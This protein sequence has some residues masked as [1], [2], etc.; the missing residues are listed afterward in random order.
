MKNRLFSTKMASQLL[1]GPENFPAEGTIT[2]YEE[3]ARNGAAIVCCSM[4]TYP[5]REGKHP[6]MS[7]IDMT[8]REVLSYFRQIT[9]RIHAYGSLASASL[10]NVEPHDVGIC[11]IPNWDEIPMDGD[12]SRN[13]AN[14]PTIS[15]DRI[16]EMIQDFA[17]QAKDFKA[18]GFDM[19]TIYMSY[20]GG[21]LAN[22]L[23]PVLNQRTD[24]YGGAPENRAR[25]SLEVFRAIKEA[26]GKDFIIECQV[27]ATEEEPGYTFEEFLDWAEKAQEY[28]DIF[29]LRAYEGALNHGNGFNQKEH[30]PYMLQYA[31]GMKE[32]GIKAIIS[33]VGCFQDLDDIERFLAEGKCDAVSMARAFICDP[34]Y[35]EKLYEGR[36]EDVVPCLRCNLCHEG[37]CRVNPRH[38]LEQVMGRM[39]PD[40]PERREKVAVIGGGP[41]GMVA[42]LTA[43]ER[44]HDV[45]L[46]ERRWTLGGQLRHVDYM[47]FKWPL[48]NYRDYLVD[49]ISKS[50][51]KVVMGR[52]PEPAEI[53]ANGY[54]AVI[55]ACGANGTRPTCVRGAG[56]ALLPMDALGNTEVGHRVVVV[57]GAD[58]GFETGLALAVAGHEVTVVSRRKHYPFDWHALKATRDYLKGLPNFTYLTCCR[59]EEIGKDYVIYTKEDGS[60]VRLD[61]DTTV[62][63][64]G[65]ISEK[66][67]AMRFAGLTTKFSAV[68]D[69]RK[70]AS[71]REAVYT[72]YCAAMQL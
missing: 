43:A 34:H 15:R 46:F 24:E 10:Q 25:M 31:Q 19:V 55:A 12:Y 70:P 56:N 47:P 22:S 72:A 52:S 3:V 50:A 32:R 6:P 48:R 1:Q 53:K 9:D 44:G 64:G 18:L 37:R 51:V 14:K 45:T 68:G 35:G 65:R 49:Q 36:G 4:G 59:T 26:C 7:N 5:D 2:F 30:E 20:R 62:F 58:I 39:F 71:L 23:S 40:K 61:C 69:V 42:A 66:E 63:S 27:S 57:G 13:L 67:E 38:G 11:Q 60:Q 21:I 33:P 41:A 8:K 16:G 29:Q 54:T 28:V 17:R